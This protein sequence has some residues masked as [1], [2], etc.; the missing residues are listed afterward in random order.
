MTE[1]L[2]AAGGIALL[3]NDIKD[4]LIE[5]LF[6]SLP[7]EKQLEILKDILLT[8]ECKCDCDFSTKYTPVFKPVRFKRGIEVEYEGGKIKKY[9]KVSKFLSEI[10]RKQINKLS[11]DNKFHITLDAQIVYYI[12]RFNQVVSIYKATPKIVKI[13]R[14]DNHG[15]AYTAT[16]R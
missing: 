5:K 14:Y 12:R 2:L 3:M 10:S 13:T 16:T 11:V 7:C 9:S 15:R 1:K 4:K 6:L 8:K